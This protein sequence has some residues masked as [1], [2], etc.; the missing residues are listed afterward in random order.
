MNYNVHPKCVNL[1]QT[2]NANKIEHIK[3]QLERLN[4]IDRR[5][6]RDDCDVSGSTDDND[7]MELRR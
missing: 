6:V 1:L 5:R 3:K 4:A 7:N 2:L